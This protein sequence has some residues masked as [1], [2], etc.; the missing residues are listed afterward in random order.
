MNLRSLFL[1][2]FVQVSFLGYSQVTMDSLKRNTEI[3]PATAQLI[4][5][6]PFAL[7]GSISVQFRSYTAYDIPERQTPFAT[8]IQ[9]NAT[10]R[11]REITVPF[12]FTLSNLQRE[13]SNPFEKKYWNGFLSNN[14]DHICRFGM[15]PFYK[16]VRLHIGHR[17]MN[18]SEFTLSNHNFLGLGVEL[19][20][21]RWRLAVMSGRLAKAEPQDLSLS[22]PNIPVFER[23]GWGA[24]IGYGT[25]KDYVDLIVFSA[26]DNPT[27]ISE[28]SQNTGILITPNDN[29]V[30]AARARKQ[31]WKYFSLEGEWAK[32]AITR[33]VEDPFSQNASFPYNGALFRQRISTE[34]KQAVSA[35]LAYNGKSAQAA[36]R[37]KRIDPG[38]QTLGAYFF[39]EDLENF[40]LE[41]Q[42]SLFR[43]RFRIFASG[44]LQHNNLDNS[45]PADF[46]RI[47]G[48]AQLQYADQFWSVGF[49]FSNFSSTVEYLLNAES[50]SLNVVVASQDLSLTLSRS[51]LDKQQRNHQITLT[52]GIQTINDNL[53]IPGGGVSSKLLFSNLSYQ[54][55]TPS[56][57]QWTV[58]VDFNRNSLV[59][60]PNNNRWGFG[61][62]LQKP[63]FRNRLD[64]GAG[65]QYYTNKSAISSS[66]LTNS[67]LSLRWKFLNN[68]SLLLQTNLIHNSRNSLGL[69]SSFSELVGTLGYS[70]A[71]GYSANGARG[72]G[73][74]IGYVPSAY[75]RKK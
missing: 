28:T 67:Y 47:I 50:D 72:T 8:T 17:Y 69:K 15:S 65:I 1:L 27:S 29:L 26:K 52:S 66:Q 4:Q 10:A 16:W 30:L 3:T 6:D 63:L 22:R 13:S 11:Y 74:P 64:A 62:R 5:K 14:H 31:L 19:T 54:L 53:D 2:L 58:S 12:A 25:T 36:F 73:A 40:T 45:K 68:H 24:K 55:T 39:N 34:F 59:N 35:A 43:N 57:W 51:I 46:K 56:R 61:T 21:G 23:M 71:F 75:S 32:S 44:G 7:N 70:L 38:Y 49:N 33:N 9:A 37:Y 18:F 60:V 42:T 20:P 41:A 48:S